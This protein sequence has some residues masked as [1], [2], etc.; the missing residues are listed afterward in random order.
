[1]PLDLTPEI[2]RGESC[3]EASKP[4]PHSWLDRM[5]AVASMYRHRH[6]QTDI[7]HVISTPRTT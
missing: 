7:L 5:A 2:T 4:Q 6:D 3:T 1:M